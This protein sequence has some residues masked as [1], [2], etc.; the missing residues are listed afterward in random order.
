MLCR[1]TIRRNRKSPLLI[2]FGI[3]LLPVTAWNL[4]LP[5]GM[6]RV[7]PHVG[8]GT[9]RNVSFR[10][11]WTSAGI[12]ITG[13]TIEFPH[14]ELS[15]PQTL[16]YRIEKLPQIDKSVGIYL[17]IIDPKHKFR[18]DRDQEQLTNGVTID[19]VDESGRRVSG[20]NS[21]LAKMYWC[22]PGGAGPDTYGLFV[23]R[24]SNASN[25]VRGNANGDLDSFFEPRQQANYE[26]HVKYEPDA[27]L[28]GL[29]GYV[30]IRCGGS[31]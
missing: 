1:E 3:A 23:M 18:H 13:Y 19:V 2:V 11:P 15:K 25:S 5:F 17:C 14:F 7:Q 12:P 30:F 27:K 31:L 26:I 21:Q 16:S 29:Q 28:E 24:G 22:E 6:P 9:F 20:V 4:H 10:Y 8:D